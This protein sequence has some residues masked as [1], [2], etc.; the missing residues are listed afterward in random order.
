[1]ERQKGAWKA[2]RQKDRKVERQKGSKA[3]R[4]QGS[5]AERQSRHFIFITIFFVVS[6]STS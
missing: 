4:Q 6:S 5:K 3:K 1:M 2:E